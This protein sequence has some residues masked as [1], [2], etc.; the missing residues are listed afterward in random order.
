MKVLVLAGGLSPERNVS[1]SSGAMVC[2][3]LRDRGHQVALMDLFYGLDG[4]LNGD[5]LYVAP[6][7][8]TYKR[9][10]REA[11]DL[12]QLRASRPGPSAIGDGVLEMCAGAD[13]VYLALHGACGEDGR[14][15]AA[16]DLLGTP[17]TGSD[18]AAGLRPGE[19]PPVGDRHGDGGEHR[20]NYGAHP[21]ACGGEAHRQRLLYRG[22][23]RQ[24][25]G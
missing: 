6:I 13:V 19:H 7:P 23:H 1:L 5:N 10:A 18:Q 3:A 9:V 25:A 16:L 11:P 4:A 15:Q 12:E 24:K 14:I 2:Q 8:D 20:R 21:A 22:V 17:Y